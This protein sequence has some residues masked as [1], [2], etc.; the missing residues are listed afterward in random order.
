M[1]RITSTQADAEKNSRTASELRRMPRSLCPRGG[2]RQQISEASDGLDDVDIQFF[3]D[4]AD[5]HLDGVGVAVEVLVVEM[6]DELGTRH[7]TAGVMHQ[8]GEQA[9]FVRGHLYGVAGDADLAGAG[10]ERD[11]TA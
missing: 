2:W 9:I 10:V 3:A 7:H 5:E 6:L 8:I 11:R 1:T 4:A